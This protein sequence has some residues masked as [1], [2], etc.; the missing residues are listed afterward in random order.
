MTVKTKIWDQIKADFK[1]GVASG[2]FQT[3]LSRTSLKEINPQQAVIEV[4]NKFVAH[5]LKENYTDQIQTIFRDNL[6]TV[7]EVRFIYADLPDCI[8][9][10]TGEDV[11]NRTVL[12]LDW[13][14]PKRTFAEFITAN[15]NRLASYSA[16]NVAQQ[17]GINYNP[18]YIYSGLSFGKTHILNAVG[19]LALQSNP[20]TKIIYLSADRF[21]NE[22][23]STPE[24][25][26]THHF[27]QTG[28]TFDFLLVDDI[29]LLA[30]HYEPQTELLSLFNSFLES[31][32][33]MVVTA[34]YAPGKIRDL[35]P[36]LRSRLEWGLIAEIHPP[37][38]RTKVR[39]IKKMARTQK[40]SFPDDVSFFLANSSDDMKTLSQY[41]VRI[42]EYISTYRSPIDISTAE[43]IIKKPSNPTYIDINHIQSVTAKYF[44]ISLRDLLSHKRERAFSYPRQ[45]AMY[46]TKQ[47]TSLSLNEI[48]CAF[49]NK[50]HSTVIYAEKSIRRAKTQNEEVSRD[51]DS[52]QK[53]LV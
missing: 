24:P 15:S 39:I 33:Q 53:L 22:V 41:I 47:L 31:K 42:K 16:M 20:G 9:A 17:P 30:G 5:W 40:L 32:R 35:L 21:L 8:K 48:G 23:S 45:A 2:E 37:D 44:N 11:K 10:Q 51:I 43:S 19:N 7:P 28:D 49:G 50:H 18:L 6:D 12:S 14:N 4:P 46:L 13:I 25:Q 27:W 38:Q 34:A 3:W 26:Q 52:I 1:T 36:Q 29:H